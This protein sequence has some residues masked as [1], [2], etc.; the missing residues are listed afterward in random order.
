M[1][2]VELGSLK[3]FWLWA[4]VG[5]LAM[6]GSFSFGAGPLFWALNA[7]CIGLLAARSVSRRRIAIAIAVGIATP[8]MVAVFDSGW[9]LVA[10]P[11]AAL[12]LA[13]VHS[14]R[15]AVVLTVTLAIAL[16]SLVI[17]NYQDDAFLA[18]VIAPVL[19]I[20]AA[21][22]AG[23]PQREAAGS[24]TGAGLA[25]LAFG[26]SAPGISLTLAGGILML[27][28]G[29]RRRRLAAAVSA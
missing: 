9:L 29:L 28:L 8:P 10:G 25:L 17:L 19:V 4:G 21:L 23:R 11:V 26:A 1:T 20:V 22:I 7:A 24:L 27:T 14:R 5:V 18:L 6:L 12:A 15:E 2:L 3:R 16:G 13:I